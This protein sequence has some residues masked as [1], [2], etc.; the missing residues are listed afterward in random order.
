M[1]PFLAIS[2]IARLARFV[3]TAAIAWGFAS[4]LKR[5]GQGRW[6]LPLIG[7]FWIGFY[8]WYWS[9]MPR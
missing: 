9:V 7:I 6:A 8:A 2:F 1:L 4:I 5:Y 3:F